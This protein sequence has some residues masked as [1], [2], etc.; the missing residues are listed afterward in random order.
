LQR[1]EELLDARIGDAVPERLAFAPEGDEALLAH[2]R[3]VLRQG[4]LRQTH[5]FREG[6]HVALAAFDE[7]A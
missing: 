2:L 1:G 4:R 5:G 6:A 3:E 7:L